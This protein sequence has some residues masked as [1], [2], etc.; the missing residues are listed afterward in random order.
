MGTVCLHVAAAMLV[1]IM[2]STLLS[3]A[4][5]VYIYHIRAYLILIL[6]QYFSTTEIKK[7]NCR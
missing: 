5:A 6:L 3:T 7:K 2:Y 4:Y 1:V